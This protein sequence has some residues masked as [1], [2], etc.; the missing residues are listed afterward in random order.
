MHIHVLIS[1]FLDVK[2]TLSVF[3]SSPIYYSHTLSRGLCDFPLVWVHL[4]LLA[5]LALGT[6]SL[7]SWCTV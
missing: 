1:E 2:R 3:M 7:K 5:S 6:F 4:A